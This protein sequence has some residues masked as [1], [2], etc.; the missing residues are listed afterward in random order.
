MITFRRLAACATVLVACI[1]PSLAFAQASDCTI[2]PTGNSI[3]LQA[4]NSKG[5]AK[6][7]VVNSYHLKVLVNDRD[8]TQSANWGI[9]LVD[10][11]SNTLVIPAW[12]IKGFP[13]TLPTDNSQPMDKSGLVISGKLHTAYSSSGFGYN[14]YLVEAPVTVKGLYDASFTAEKVHVFAVTE[15]CGKSDRCVPATP[16]NTASLGMMGVGFQPTEFEPAKS[17]MTNNSGSAPVTAVQTN[18]FEYAPGV[19]TQGWIFHRDGHIVVGL[20]TKT[21]KDFTSWAPMVQVSAG[22]MSPEGCVVV[23]TN[24]PKGAATPQKL[25]GSML[26]DTGMSAMNLWVQSEKSALAAICRLPL[27]SPSAGFHGVQFPSSTRIEIFSPGRTAQVLNY[28]FKTVPLA[29]KG[30]PIVSHPAGT[31]NG[32]FCTDDSASSPSEVANN[33]EAGHFNTGRM[34]LLVSSLARNESCGTFAWKSQVIQST[35]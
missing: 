13:T 15:T 26:V 5:N 25:C 12:R 8:T 2:S 33:P 34:P 7:D 1:P 31:P 21:T 22:K 10:T 3:A 11:G 30:A 32:T 19:K 9:V 24:G 17:P 20:N 4:M 35:K 16:T 18:V 6:S 14:G 27:T 28:S 29:K 23:T